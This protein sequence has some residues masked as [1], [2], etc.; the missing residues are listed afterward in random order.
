MV[1]VNIDKQGN[2]KIPN[3]FAI[4]L[5]IADNVGITYTTNDIMLSNLYMDKIEVSETCNINIPKEILDKVGI[6]Q[7]TKLCAFIEE[8]YIV[9]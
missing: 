8:E 5:N 6:S 2:I 7:K 4:A 9:T 1:L 3:E